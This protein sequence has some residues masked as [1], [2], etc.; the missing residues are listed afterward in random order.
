MPFDT[1]SEKAEADRAGPPHQFV[2]TRWSARFRLALSRTKPYILV[3]GALYLGA[4]LVTFILRDGLILPE[5]RWL[6]RLEIVQQP[7]DLGGGF[8]DWIYVF[9]RNIVAGLVG[10]ATAGVPGILINAY[11]LGA[12]AA[13][14][15]AADKAG[16]FWSFILP[17][18]LFE[19][20][21]SCVATG[22]GLRFG[23]SLLARIRRRTYRRGEVRAALADGFVLWVGLIVPATAVAAL[24]EVE[25]S[26]MWMPLPL[27]ILFGAFAAATF[28]ALIFGISDPEP[29][30][31]V[32]EPASTVDE[33]DAA[34][35][36][37]DASGSEIPDEDMARART[38]LRDI[39]GGGTAFELLWK[40]APR[41]ARVACIRMVRRGQT[42]PDPIS[43]AVA[44]GFARR[45]LSFP[46]N[47][48]T[49][50]AC[51]LS[52]CLLVAVT[53]M[54]WG[55]FIVPGILAAALTLWASTRVRRT[56]R[57]NR[58]LVDQALRGE[59][60]IPSPG[61]SDGFEARFWAAIEAEVPPAPPA[62][63]S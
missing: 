48:A 53:D 61:T 18:G 51:A 14:V 13:S 4:F 60:P 35:A 39:A 2:L 11:G 31:V 19:I 59:V 30:M 62:T 37:E 47:L 12:S 24:I 55:D 16:I 63:A 43:A 7:L 22:V 21:T 20:A 17:H 28:V 9:Q 42:A 23:R 3:A 1:V 34:P 8:A 27:A 36:E 6:L 29:G 26:T 41:K 57:V 5:D 54:A 58:E 15:H 10:I 38:I 45:S 50:I 33:Q 52:M 44:A 32:A 56:E 40:R 49:W 25:L 46:N